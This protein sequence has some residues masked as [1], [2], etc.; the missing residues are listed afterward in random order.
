[1]IKYL[2]SI[3]L[4]V[5]LFFD[6]SNEKAR[7]LYIQYDLNYINQHTWLCDSKR[8]PTFMEMNQNISRGYYIRKPSALFSSF[9]LFLFPSDIHMFY[10]EELF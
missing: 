10:N 8:T 5:D 3:H 2:K 7:K 4:K 9:F 1:M 6:M